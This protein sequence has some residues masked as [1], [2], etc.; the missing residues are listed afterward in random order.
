ML[1]QTTVLLFLS[2]VM[3]LAP[4]WLPLLVTFWGYSQFHSNVPWVVLAICSFCIKNK[5]TIY[6]FYIKIKPRL[7]LFCKWSTFKIVF[8][9][10]SFQCLGWNKYALF[11][12]LLMQHCNSLLHIQFCH[13]YLFKNVVTSILGRRSNSLDLIVTTSPCYTSLLVVL[14]L[15]VMIFFNCI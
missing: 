13:L 8:M 1:F 11:N 7:L 2:G 6:S 10:F 3:V 4:H 9:Y 14:K 12:S 5:H 15:L